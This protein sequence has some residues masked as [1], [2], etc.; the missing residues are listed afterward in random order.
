MANVAGVWL[1][2]GL[3]LEAEAIYLVGVR[4]ASPFLQYLGI[5]AFAHS[6]VRLG[7]T[8]YGKNWTPPLV[9]HSVLFY[10]NRIVRRPN[11]L[12]S[13]AAAVLVAGVIFIETPVA[14]LGCGWIVLAVALF[15]IGLRAGTVDFRGQAYVA[16]ALGAVAAV[17]FGGVPAL[18]ISLGLVYTTAVRTKWL[19]LEELSDLAIASSGI[20]VAL[21]FAL[22][23]GVP[24]DY[25]AVSWFALALATIE[26]GNQKLPEQMRWFAAPGGAL[27]LA[28]LVFTHNSDY[29]QFP[30][31]AVW[32]SFF[33]CAALAALAALR[34]EY[35]AAIRQ[36]FV[37]TAAGLTIAGIWLVSPDP[38][39]TV[40][41]TVVALAVLE[42][43]FRNLRDSVRADFRTHAA[44][45][46]QT[47]PR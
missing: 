35:S 37:A 40:L 15:E 26:L 16:A 14:W 9:F 28:G 12:M 17:V 42:L 22:L 34:I 36:G 24:I 1:S 3:A 13:T 5:A 43:R 2:A 30:A 21:A 41:W 23:A 31:P 19:D 32:V 6:L 33:G 18:G 29:A 4:F 27:E 38:Y 8:P 39:V 45:R 20:A 11:V 44:L 10:V 7:L 25:V 47:M 46:Y